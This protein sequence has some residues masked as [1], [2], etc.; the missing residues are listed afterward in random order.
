MFS[1]LKKLFHRPASNIAKERLQLILPGSGLAPPF[2]ERVKDDIIQV[3]NHYLEI[4]A[5]AAQVACYQESR[6]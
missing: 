4:D 1:F 3:V 6:L 2:L 5:A